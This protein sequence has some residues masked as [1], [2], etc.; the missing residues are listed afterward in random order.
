MVKVGRWEAEIAARLE[1]GESRDEIWYWLMGEIINAGGT[2]EQ[3]S[4]YELAF[5]DVYTEDRMQ[6]VRA[7][8][9]EQW[10]KP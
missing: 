4:G 9:R 7:A 5:I 3:L 8:R 2:R 1:R 6:Q 10:S